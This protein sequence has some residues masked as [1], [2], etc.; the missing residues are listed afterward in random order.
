M[1]AHLHLS[2]ADLD[3]IVAYFEAM[4]ARKHDPRARP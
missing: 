2:D 3:A 4:R 1:P